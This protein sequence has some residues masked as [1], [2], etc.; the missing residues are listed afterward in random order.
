VSTELGPAVA[1][2]PG[3]RLEN[4]D[5]VLALH[6]PAMSRDT[7]WLRVQLLDAAADLLRTGTIR[8]VRGRQ[9]VEL[10]PNIVGSRQH[11]IKAVREFVVARQHRHVFTLYVTPDGLDDDA[12]GPLHGGVIAVLGRR[13][14]K[15]H[16]HLASRFDVDQ[17]LDG[18]TTM[19]CMR[20]AATGCGQDCA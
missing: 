2:V 13:G 6:T 10:L 8:V 19:Q 3:A 20:S 9:V 5:G 17:L 1:S 7:V 15:A 4:K 14:A 11:A 16:V 12:S 18:L